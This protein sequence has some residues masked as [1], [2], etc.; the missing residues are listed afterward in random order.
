[1]LCLIIWLIK[2]LLIKL[3][4]AKPSSEEVSCGLISGY[5]DESEIQT[6]ALAVE[7]CN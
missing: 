3:G 6:S 2:Q 5:R 4:L 1:M 7:N